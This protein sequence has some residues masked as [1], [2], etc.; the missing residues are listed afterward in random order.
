MAPELR[1]TLDA[2]SEGRAAPGGGPAGG[3]VVRVTLEHV[4][5]DAARDL[6][7]RL[8]LPPGTRADSAWWAG[9]GAGQ[10]PGA[11]G[12]REVTWSG[13]EVRP[14]ERLGPLGV[15]L[16]PAAAGA[17]D[18]VF[19][20]ARV[21]PEVTWRRPGAGRAGAPSLALN[22]LWG[23][24]SLRRTVL[25]TGLTL[26]TRERPGSPTV[27][28]RV[29][30]R[31]G[32][33][34]EDAGARG[35]S[36]WLEHAH[37]LGTARRPGGAP[38]IGELIASVGGTLNANTGREHTDYWHLVPAAHF[39]LSLDVLADQFL[40]ST[41][42]REA[43]ERERQVVYE[44]LKAR[45]EATVTRASDEFLRLVFRGTPLRF[46]A[47][48]TVDSVRAI[49]V[50][51]ILAYRAQRYVTGNVAVA[52]AGDLRHDEAVAKLAAA[53][54]ALPEGRRSERAFASE[55]VPNVPPDL[56]F[57]SG[58]SGAEVRAGWA[59]P[60]I[61]HPDYWAMGLLTDVLGA[62]GRRLSESVRDRRGLAS[63]ISAQ[64][65]AFSDAS[66]LMIAAATVPAQVREVIELSVREVQRLRDGDLSADD[67]AR[68]KRAFAGRRSLGQEL[69]QGQTELAATE[70]SATA[71]SA[72]EQLA[73]LRA[74]GPADIQRVARQYLVPDRLTRV[75]VR[76]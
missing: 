34:D 60:G 19:Q 50:E 10:R 71:R 66:A 59:G 68:A 32:A 58:S 24:T 30:V 36:H 2:T 43:F 14:G 33:R 38:E 31:A 41:F 6:R 40:H 65:F 3:L 74:V 61:N 23:E 55:A 18:T 62:T 44:E 7:V 1:V 37:F 26:L 42:P 48:G 51:T 21:R 52:V 28:L 17:G 57:G 5:G 53:F 76:Q 29:A 13:L 4:A 20:E 16:L 12:G 63:S 39:D 47:G 8:P 9:A 15:R 46:D 56:S 11:A 73:R 70:V 72:A 27:A 64:L 35:G 54:A 69:N 75:V 49:P 67:V 45:M 22:G 25:P